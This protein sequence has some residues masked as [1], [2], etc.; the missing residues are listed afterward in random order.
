MRFRERAAQE[1]GEFLAVLGAEK[2]ADLGALAAEAQ[3]QAP[4]Q[5][6]LLVLLELDLDPAAG[7]AQFLALLVV[8]EAPEDQLMRR[9]LDPL[10]LQRIGIVLAEG[11]PDEH[12][13][14]A[15]EGCHRP[16]A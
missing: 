3:E 11:P 2:A 6:A 13:I 16:G 15:K 7:E 8:V 9:H 14:D 1:G 4:D 10:L 5:V 12:D